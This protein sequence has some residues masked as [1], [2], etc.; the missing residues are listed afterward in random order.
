MSQVW[1]NTELSSTEKI[2]M[3]SLAD[4]ANDE[5]VCYPS[6]TRLTQRTGLSERAVQGA[7]KRLREGG[8]LSV[9]KNAGRAGSNLY[10]LHLTPAADAPP[11]E[12]H[13]RSR[14]TPPPQEVRVTPAA[15]A[16]KPSRTINEPSNKVQSMPAPS[17]SQFWE[18]WTLRKVNRKKAEAAFKRLSV[19]NKQDAIDR[20]QDWITEWRAANPDAN[21]IHPTSYLNG[22]RWT[23]EFGP[24]QQQTPKANKWNQIKARAAT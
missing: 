8:Y 20:V 3:L 23:D 13:P 16:P 6:V 9:E 22:A 12:M 18:R 1:D 5:G 10:T 2:V 21:A 14:C 19:K 15:G 11:H 7:M 24:S 4:H 17:F